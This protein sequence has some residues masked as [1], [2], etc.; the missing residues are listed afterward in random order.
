MPGA[1]ALAGPARPR[2][3]PRRAGGQPRAGRRPRACRRRAAAPL[4]QLFAVGPCGLKR[5]THHTSPRPTVPRPTCATHGDRPT[6]SLPASACMR[7]R[8]GFDGTMVH[9]VHRKLTACCA[10]PTDAHNS[11]EALFASDHA[12]S[13]SVSH[14]QRMHAC[15]QGGVHA[16]VHRP[17]QCDQPRTTQLPP[18]IH[19]TLRKKGRPL[20]SVNF[21]S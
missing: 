2:G 11:A 4:C 13:W 9:A 1:A 6:A 7:A 8:A 16:D 14:H 19:G 17:H 15:L 21:W 12:C 10:R 5:S 3:A 20:N 18:T